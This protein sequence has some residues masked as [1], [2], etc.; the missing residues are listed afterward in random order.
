[1]VDGKVKD[2]NSV[3]LINIVRD[4]LSVI[5]YELLFAIA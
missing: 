5:T 2:F 1:M 3:P 4:A